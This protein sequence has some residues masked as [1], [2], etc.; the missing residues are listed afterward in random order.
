MLDQEARALIRELHEEIVKLKIRVS[1][2]E[3]S[4]EDWIAQ[5]NEQEKVVD[6]IEQ[7]LQNQLERE[8]PS[9]V[10]GE[11]VMEK[12]KQIDEIAY[13]RFASVYRQF[14]DVSSFLDELQSLMKDK[15][16]E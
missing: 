7:Q 8:V 4:Y 14:K 5:Q 13:V 12:L 6:E 16:Q 1:D 9:S 2:L 11:L 3:L 10:I 15:K